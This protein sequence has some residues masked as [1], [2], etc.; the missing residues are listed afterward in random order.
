MK[1]AIKVISILFF[2]AAIYLLL[3]K[4]GLF[5]EH[6]YVKNFVKESGIF[7]PLVFSFLYISTMVFAPLTGFPIFIIGVGIF[8]IINTIILIYFISQIG[9]AVNFWISRKFGK[10]ILIKL[11]GKRGMIRIDS[12]TSSFGIEALILT[13]LFQGFLFEWISYAAGLSNLGFKKYILIT[14][15]ASIPQLLLSLFIGL[16]VKNLG[17][18]FI[19][20]TLINYLLLPV[21]I[22]YFL[23][24]KALRGK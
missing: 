17:E 3:Q 1:N 22:F 14:I 10:K 20:V 18:L 19:A 2:L 6:D 24:K 23:F 7:A 5:L 9:A 16:L 11:V 8:G 21:P 15:F 13:R 12:L 4:L